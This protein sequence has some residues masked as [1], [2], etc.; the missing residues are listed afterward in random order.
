MIIPESVTIVIIVAIVTLAYGTWWLWW[1]LPKRQMDRLALKIRDPKARADVEDN[2]RKTVG[3]ALGGA[4][5]LVGAGSALFQFLHQQQ[6][7][8]QQQR[9]AQEQFLAQQRSAHD[10]LIS[11]QVSKGF[12]LLASKQLTMRLGGIYALE[13][14]MNGSEQY[15]LP[16]LETL[17]AFVRDQTFTIEK[18]LDQ[19]PKL[20]TDVQAVLTVIGR[21]AKG[22]GEI[23]LKNAKIPNARL[24]HADLAGADLNGANL[25]GAELLES[26]LTGANLVQT[27]LTNAA[28]SDT[29]LTGAFLIGTDLTGAN[30]SGAN[31]TGVSVRLGGSQIPRAGPLNLTG[32]DLTRANLTD[33]DLTG[34]DLTG[35]NLTGTNLTSADLT[36]AN[37]T[38]TNLTGADL[39]G[40]NL[41]KSHFQ[42]KQAQL[43]GACGKDAKLPAGLTLKPCPKTQGKAP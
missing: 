2:L 7:A 32:A 16:V 13:A 29:D 15:R 3:Q 39:T 36:G 18:N 5:V 41:A 19:P 1:R 12:E 21:R 23:G 17:C 42:V 33:A 43:D 30:L 8:Q 10:V 26:N 6:A 28:L 40:A 24:N 9:V 4:A 34:A 14:V 27:D 22:P 37:L 25:R 31:L 35:A 38:G 20:A 11:N